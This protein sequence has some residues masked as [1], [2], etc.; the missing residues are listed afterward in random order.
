M[1]G[2]AQSQKM[3]GRS[4]CRNL[5]DLVWFSD[6]GPWKEVRGSLFEVFLLEHFLSNPSLIIA[7]PFFGNSVVL[8]NF[9]Q[10]FGF[11]RVVTW[12]SLTC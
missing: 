5:L 6:N 11:V 2:L 9:A 7:L 8:L 10:I 12:I 1:F 4:S 3:D